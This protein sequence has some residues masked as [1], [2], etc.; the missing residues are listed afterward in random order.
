M[1]RMI[2]AAIPPMAKTSFMS[3][4]PTISIRTMIRK[5]KMADE[6]EP[7]ITMPVTSRMGP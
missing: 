7:I 1:S 2:S 4:P 6:F 3:M 5:R